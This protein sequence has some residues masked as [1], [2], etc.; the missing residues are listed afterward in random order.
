MGFCSRF[1]H[2]KDVKVRKSINNLNF[3]CPVCG[4]KVP[5]DVFNTED[6]GMT[7]K[8]SKCGCCVFEELQK[9]AKW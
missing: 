9:V 8:C 2:R 7:Y 6:Y 4:T 5:K 3:K 1:K